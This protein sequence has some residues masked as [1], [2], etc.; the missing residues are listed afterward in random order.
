MRNLKDVSK[1]KGMRG[2]RGQKVVEAYETPGSGA[3]VI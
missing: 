2:E 1:K 3:G